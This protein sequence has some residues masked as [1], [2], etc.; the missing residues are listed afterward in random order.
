MRGAAA[1]AVRG[2]ARLARSTVA[3]APQRRR[4]RP[5]TPELYS[6]KVAPHCSP[7]VASRL[8]MR[9]RCHAN[10]DSGF[11]SWYSDMLKMEL[12]VS[13]TAMPDDQM[14]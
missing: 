3:R 12:V 7:D 6:A 2:A 11:T 8:L 9:T 14:R 1:A 4:Q 10:N 13:M 5:L